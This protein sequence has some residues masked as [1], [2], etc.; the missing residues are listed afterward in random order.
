MCCFVVHTTC[1]FHCSAA[2]V[3]CSAVCVASWRDVPEGGLEVLS[4]KRLVFFSCKLSFTV[5]RSFFFFFFFFSVSPAYFLVYWPDELAVTAVE[6]KKVMFSKLVV[7]EECQVQ[8][9][10]NLE[11][12]CLAA[13]G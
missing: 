4:R 6:K 12:G 9:G 2:C 7:G 8:F 13:W 10:K 3:H 5:L 11:D 1:S